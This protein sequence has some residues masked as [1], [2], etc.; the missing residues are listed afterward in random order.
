[1]GNTGTEAN[2]ISSLTGPAGIQGPAGNDGA[3]GA[4]GS[5]GPTGALGP[6][7][8]K[9]DPGDPGKSAYE[10]WRDLGNTGTEANFISS[11]TGPAGVQGPAGNDGAVG[12]QGSVG[13]TGAPG[14]QGVKGDPG[15]PGKSAYEVWRDLGNTGTEANF[16]SSLTGPAGVQGPA[17]NDGAVGAQGPIGP[18]GAQGPKGDRGDV[19]PAGANGL[20]TSVNGITQVGG[21]ITLTK[22]DLSLGNVDNTSDANKPVSTATQTALD[23]KVDKVSGKGLL[24]NGTA[25]GNT[26][27]WNGS[28]W[29][30]SSGNIY[31][32]GNQVGIGTIT[33]HSSA[34]LEIQSITQG[35]LFPRMTLNQRDAIASP[36]IGLTVFNTTTKCINFFVGTAWNEL[37]GTTIGAITSLNCG[38]S[39]TNGSFVTQEPVIGTATIPYDGGNGGNYREQIIFST[40]ITG[41]TATLTAGTFAN[42]TGNLVYSITGNPASSGS[43]NFAIEIGGKNCT[44]SIDVFHTVV[45]D[46]VSPSGKIWMDRNLGASRVATS[47]DDIDSFGSLYQWGRGTDGHQNRNSATIT[48]LSNTD[49][50]GHGDFI[51]NANGNWRNPS[52]NNLWQGI[53]GVNNPCPSGYRIP[54][55]VEWVNELSTWNASYSLNPGFN[56]P[57]KLPRAG[58]RYGSSIPSS[59]RGYYWSDT[60][61]N[62]TSSQYLLFFDYEASTQTSVS[63]RAI[64]Y[65]V[66][67]IKN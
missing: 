40:G 60:Y 5:V 38:A 17:G 64:G 1:M 12:A 33:P 7:G 30:E 65:S 42:G 6:Q 28:Q 15:D 44:F 49:S 13:A 55:A 54:T 61:A 48:T 47:K 63:G 27:Y 51:S 11:L 43:A 19:G 35:F 20:T 8:V 2:F 9:G 62:S 4:Q 67:C 39:T 21:A 3:I 24:T 10:V 56:S 45:V 36:A 22:A 46:V 29:I 14:P 16:I 57:L 66:R 25:A 31:N 53:N 37:C 34:K 52:N 26:P 58:Y 41:L 59:D 23:T 32:D 50:P 18:A